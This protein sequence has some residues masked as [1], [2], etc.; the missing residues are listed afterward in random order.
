MSSCLTQMMPLLSVLF[1]ILCLANCGVPLTLNFI[2]EFLSLYG[3]FERLPLMGVFASSSII[4]SA[5]YSIYLFNRVA[6]GGGFSKFFK[7]NI[8][9]LTKREFFLLF[10]LVTFAVILG[11]YPSIIFDGLHY[12]ITNLIYSFNN[13]EISNSLITLAGLPSLTRTGLHKT[14]DDCMNRN[15]D[16]RYTSLS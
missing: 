6:F 16:K 15:L 8:S 4:F 13:I 12:S 1:F 14:D 10:S 7:E 3:T 9:D 2:G 11:I 5:A